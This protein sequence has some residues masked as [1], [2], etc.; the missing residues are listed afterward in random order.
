M[1]WNPTIAEQLL[2]REPEVAQQM[3]GVRITATEQLAIIGHAGQLVRII[4]PKR[5][6]RIIAVHS[7]L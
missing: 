5:L 4:A 7:S 2:D 6:F 3:V 1:P